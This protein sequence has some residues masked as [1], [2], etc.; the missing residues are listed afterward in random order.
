VSFYRRWDEPEDYLSLMGLA[1]T[2]SR[3]VIR[4]TRE[5]LEG[6]V[7]GYKEVTVPAQSITAKNST[8]L[9][10]KPASKADFVRGKAGFF[11]FS[12]G[13]V[14]A[15][16]ANERAEE[17]ERYEAE[18]EER[19]G[20]DGLLRVAP[21]MS[22]GLKF[23]TENVAE[24][25]EDVE[26]EKFTFGDVQ[27]KRAPKGVSSTPAKDDENKPIAE[28]DSMDDLL[29]AE[30]P[31]LAPRGDLYAPLVR[32]K[33]KEWAHMVDVNQELTNFRELVPIMAKEWSFELDTFQKEAV[34][35]LEQGDSVFVAAHTSAGKTVVA[36]YAIALAAK[37]MTK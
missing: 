23:E 8:S 9:L 33:N 26:A 20:R 35:H 18:M 16:S 6:K 36:E 2:M 13:G 37:H 22:R 25:E 1:P 34:Y 30:F 21:G 17:L 3:T 29:P 24:V 14:D 10:R 19:I 31:M 27:P 4:F 5:G 11:P 28:L 32:Q 15:G 12:P 7:T